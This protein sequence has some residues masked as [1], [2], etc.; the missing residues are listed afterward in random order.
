M[1]ESGEFSKVEIH[2]SNE[3]LHRKKFPCLSERSIMKRVFKRQFLID[4]SCERYEGQF[5]T[6]SFLSQRSTVVDL[7][8]SV[9]LST[10]PQPPSPTRKQIYNLCEA[11]IWELQYHA[12]LLIFSIWTYD[13]LFF[14]TTVAPLCVAEHLTFKNPSEFSQKIPP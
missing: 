5:V 7:V 13:H 9:P 4:S 3:E 14:V 2:A 12:S 8:R 10:K 11:Q 1:A 6:A